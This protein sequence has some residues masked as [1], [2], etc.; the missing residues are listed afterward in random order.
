MTDSYTLDLASKVAYSACVHRPK[1]LLKIYKHA[2]GDLDFDEKPPTSYLNNKGL[3]YIDDLTIGL[4]ECKL[5]DRD[6]FQATRKT[7][8]AIAHYEKKMGKPLDIDVITSRTFMVNLVVA[9]YVH[10]VAFR[11]SDNYTCSLQVFDGIIFISQNTIPKDG[12]KDQAFFNTLYY[13]R[14]FKQMAHLP[15]SSKSLDVSEIKN[16]MNK[17]H[18]N[19]SEDDYQDSSLFTAGV[20]N[21]KI[22]FISASGPVF[23]EASKIT[24]KEYFDKLD[25]W[26]VPDSEF[27]SDDNESHTVDPDNQFIHS[28]STLKTAR[29]GPNGIS[30]SMSKKMLSVWISN[31]ISGYGQS[32]FG[33]WGDTGTLEDSMLYETSTIPDKIPTV[34]KS[35]QKKIPGAQ[36]D[37][38]EYIGW[39]QKVMEWI[40]ETVLLDNDESEKVQTWELTL[41]KESS[42][43]TLRKTAACSNSDLIPKEFTKWRK[44]CKAKEEA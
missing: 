6:P 17:K 22:A 44:Q 32:F 34:L 8:E 13:S 11:H 2:N 10:R 16:L 15:V 28:Y 7:A 29:M 27:K 42:K 14:K 30:A 40:K 3:D 31:I 35:F 12:N 19:A 23:D 26:Y 39:Y 41:R 24:D 43:I 37:P 25:N 4:K 36:W 33:F 20:G 18:N 38:E 5:E 9:R 21:V 1:R